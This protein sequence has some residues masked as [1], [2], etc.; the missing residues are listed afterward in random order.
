MSNNKWLKGNN[1]EKRP[2][3]KKEEEEEPE[4]ETEESETEETPLEE[5]EPEKSESS[6][7]QAWQEFLKEEDPK[8]VK[9]DKKK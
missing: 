1:W 2:K 9:E 5:V 8:P 4:T 6:D 3:K 7:V